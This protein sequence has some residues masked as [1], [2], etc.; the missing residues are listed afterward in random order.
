MSAGFPIESQA[1]FR[2][3]SSQYRN[4]FPGLL[5]VHGSMGEPVRW[6]TPS[7]HTR[8][9]IVPFC[10]RVYPV[11]L[12][13]CIRSF[14]SLAATGPSFRAQVGASEQSCRQSLASSASLPQVTCSM[15]SDFR[16][17]WNAEEI[18]RQRHWGVP[19]EAAVRGHRL[20]RPPM[21]TCRKH[22]GTQ[23]HNGRA[24]VFLEE[25][26]GSAQKFRRRHDSDD[27]TTFHDLTEHPIPIAFSVRQTKAT[28][29]QVTSFQKTVIGLMTG[30]AFS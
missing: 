13:P 10:R 25:P 15:E 2:S 8:S 24:G 29:S 28:T 12:R 1:D 16:Q 22:T 27:P 14:H 26:I 5:E 20:R 23:R 7:G 3:V 11:Q 21:A 4:F 19:K 30:S 9:G 18:V 17:G 6:T